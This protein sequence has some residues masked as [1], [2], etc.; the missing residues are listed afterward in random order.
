[1]TTKTQILRRKILINS[2]HLF[3]RVRNAPQNLCPRDNKDSISTHT[4]ILLCIQFD[5]LCGSIFTSLARAREKKALHVKKV[6]AASINVARGNEGERADMTRRVQTIADFH[7]SRCARFKGGL[8]LVSQYEKYYCLV[9]EFFIIL[10][11]RRRATKSDSIIR[12]VLKRKYPENSRST[13]KW[14]YT[15]VRQKASR[16]YKKVLNLRE[17]HVEKEGTQTR[18]SK[19]V[20]Y[21]GFRLFYM[22]YC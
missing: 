6:A 5:A 8:G 16:L 22:I 9:L 18:N 14:S 20:D 11:L 7:S 1:M 15:D 4:Y 3:H 17:A 19:R 21:L 13:Q 12:K 2:G 10:E